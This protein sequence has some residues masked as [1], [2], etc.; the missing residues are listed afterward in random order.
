MIMGQV[1]VFRTADPVGE[2]RYAIDG[3]AGWRAQR[4]RRKER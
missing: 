2:G 4:R 1:R 3:M